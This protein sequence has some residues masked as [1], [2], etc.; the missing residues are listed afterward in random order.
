MTMAVWV[1]LVD[2]APLV[3]EGFRRVLAQGA[4]VRD[5]R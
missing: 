3:R 4:D 5:R 1:L 2:D